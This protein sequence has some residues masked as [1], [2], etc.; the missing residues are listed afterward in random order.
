MHA[1]LTIPTIVVKP[2]LD[3]VQEV[4]VAVGKIITGVSKCVGQWHTDKSDRVSLFLIKKQLFL[5]TKDDNVFQATWQNLASLSRKSLLD[6]VKRAKT[7]TTDKQDSADQE[8]PKLR[9]RRLYKI[10]SEEKPAFPFRQRNFHGTV[11]ENKEI[12][13]ILSMLGGCTQ[14]V[15]EVRAV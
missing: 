11:M 5:N 13:K 9:R 12:V 14:S 1:T 15:R 2:S 6:V 3:Q 4:L 10:L 7:T 8:D